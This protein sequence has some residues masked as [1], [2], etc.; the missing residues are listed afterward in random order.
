MAD[1]LL[2]TFWF[3]RAAP[4]PSAF[5]TPAGTRVVHGSSG[6]TSFATPPPSLMSC[7]VPVPAAYH[8]GFADSDFVRAGNIPRESWNKST[9]ARASTFER[10]GFVDGQNWIVYDD[11]RGGFTFPGGSTCGSTR[12]IAGAVMRRLG[13]DWRRLGNFSVL[14]LGSGVA[15]FDA[16]MAD[17]AGAQAVVSTV[18]ES[19]RSDYAVGAGERGD[20]AVQTWASAERGLPPVLFA[21][22]PS[23]RF[24]SPP[25]S[26]DLVYSCNLAGGSI[27]WEAWYWYEVYRLLKP[28]GVTF[29]DTREWE[30]VPNLTALCFEELAPLSFRNTLWYPGYKKHNASGYL[31]PNQ[32]GFPNV[33]HFRAFHS[34]FASVLSQMKALRKVPVAACE[35]A[36]RHPEVA[37]EGKLT[38]HGPVERCLR[39]VDQPAT[40][41]TP[42]TTPS[43]EGTP[44][45]DALLA[46][47]IGPLPVAFTQSLAPRSNVVTIL[48]VDAARPALADALRALAPDLWGI[49][50]TNAH[51]TSTLSPHGEGSLLT[52]DA[53]GVVLQDW[54]SSSFPTHPR[55]FDVIVVPSLLHLLHG[56]ALHAADLRATLHH[57]R[58]EWQRLLR[59]GGSLLVSGNASE[60]SRVT[61]SLAPFAQNPGNASAARGLYSLRMYGYFQPSKYPNQW[62]ALLHLRRG[63]VPAYPPSS[64]AD[65]P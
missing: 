35:H 57:V 60:Y 19:S 64:R 47:F 38:P 16:A 26:F 48:N 52:P 25:E 4:C 24:P 45:F 27:K 42:D 49:S 10:T 36:R 31:F 20:Y 39:T 17:L 7:A 6:A 50:P 2:H 44:W 21:V 51:V 33:L 12:S 1:D 28:G 58:L 14:D 29:V 46:A 9:F 40:T 15:S 3:S 32:G 22:D 41:R 54:C 59:P 53:S 65:L 61:K 56:C 43:S 63:D 23:R 18:L 62:I 34:G 11:E 30:R 55:S 8:A 37:C 5:H 13:Y